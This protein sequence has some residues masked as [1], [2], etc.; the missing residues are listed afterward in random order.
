MVAERGTRPLLQEQISERIRE[1]IVDTYV[2][3]MVEQL[4]EVPKIIPQD[5]ILQRTMK[6]I[7]D[8]TEAKRT[9][10]AKAE[11]S[12][13]AL[14]ASQ[15]VSKSSY[16]QV[17][18]DHETS[19]RAFADELK[20][21][22]E[23][24][25]VL[26][27][28]TSGADGQTYSLLQESSSA[29]L[30]TST[31]LKGFEL[32]I[33][34][35]RLA[36][37]EHSTALAQPGSR[38]STT[39]KFGAGVDGDLLVKVKDLIMDLIRLQAEA[40]SETNQKSS[41][42]EE[43]SKATEKREDLE[44]DVAKHSSKL[45]AAVARSI[46]L[47]GEISALQSVQHVVNTVEVEKPKI[48]ELTVQRKKPI[49]QEK[50]NHRTKPIEFPQAQFLNKVDET[51]VAVQRQIPMVQ[52]VEEMKETP[53][54]QV[55]DKVVD[56]PVV[57]V[58]RVQVLEKTAESPQ[59]QNVEKIGEIPQTRTIQGTQAPES[60]TITPVCQVRQTRHEE[61]LVE[62]SKVFSPDTVQQRFGKQMIKIP[63]ETQMIQSARTSESSVTAPVCQ[64]TQVEIG[65]VI[66]VG[67]SIPAESTSSIFVT[68]PVLENS[69]VVVG[70]EQPAHVAE[71]MTLE[72]MVSEIRDLKSDLVHIRE[73]LGVLVRKERSA[74]A[75]AE[76][77]ARRLNRMERERDQ[78]SEAE[79]EATTLEEANGL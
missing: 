77:A 70:S 59:L 49:I 23:A 52:T 78:E 4:L 44:T 2:S 54:L 58:P 57:Q 37:Q 34:V 55:I 16:T 19:G 13:A 5:R 47:D 36:E 65:E 38:I 73:L 31:D 12:L 61:E 51:P 18:S 7:V 22:A 69:P 32:V 50:I 79:C 68:A 46:E 48:I 75:K 39:M 72:P 56:D 21:L 67:A 42:D 53:Q 24:T 15:A 27:S 62:V 35:R 74:E 28:E 26:Q 1:Q 8:C 20:A 10:L 45:E 43:M 17:D 71:Y 66:E 9:D 76:I 11:K 6:Q 29:A 40:S 41:C 33:S 60:L 63:A 25:Q 30:Q 14:M 64:T 3:Q